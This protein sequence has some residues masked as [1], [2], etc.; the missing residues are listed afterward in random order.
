[1]QFWTYEGHVV[2]KQIFFPNFNTRPHILTNTFDQYFKLAI[3]HLWFEQM[4]TTAL[5]IS[6]PVYATFRWPGAALRLEFRVLCAECCLWTPRAMLVE[7]ASLPTFSIYQDCESLF[8]AFLRVSW[9][10]G[11]TCRQWL[12]NKQCHPTSLGTQC[13]TIELYV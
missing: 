3:C 8:V 12:Q 5:F 4:A 10:S 2:I 9:T 6:S 1:M 7:S 13:K 11:E